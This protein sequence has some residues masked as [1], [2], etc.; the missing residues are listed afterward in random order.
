M[1]NEDWRSAIFFV[2]AISFVRVEVINYKLPHNNGNID[3]SYWLTDKKTKENS[4][5]AA[6]LQFFIFN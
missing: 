2:G 5:V 6:L 1:G 4:I 3:R